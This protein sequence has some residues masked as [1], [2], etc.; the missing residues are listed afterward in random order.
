M[1]KKRTSILKT[2]VLSILATLSLLVGLLP[3]AALAETSN[4]ISQDQ[5]GKYV[6]IDDNI[7]YEQAVETANDNTTESVDST[8]NPD[9]TVQISKEIQQTGENEFQIDLTVKTKEELSSIEIEPDAAV[10]LVIDVSSSMQ[11][12]T[13]GSGYCWNEE[14]QQYGVFFENAA[15][16]DCNDFP[17]GT[18]MWR[19]NGGDQVYAGNP[20]NGEDKWDNSRLKGVV[21]AL[22]GEDG[23]L[24]SYVSGAGDGK[25][26]V[27]VVIFKKVAQELVGWTDVN[28]ANN[29][30]GMTTVTEKINNLLI[31]EYTGTGT[32]IAQGLNQVTDYREID[33][34]GEYVILLTD[35][36][37]NWKLDTT[38]ME[39]TANNHKGTDWN[40]I[41]EQA[42][43]IK[44]Y[45]D[46]LFVVD[47]LS[48]NG[49]NLKENVASQLG[50]Y[51]YA[52][53]T[54]N[55]A[56]ELRL[57]FQ[58]ISEEISK[59]AT[60]W[61]V[62]DPMG[63]Y[64]NYEEVTGGTSFGDE[65]YWF[66][67]NTLYWNLRRADSEKNVDGWAEV[68]TLSYKITLDTSA[69][70]F[71]GGKFY[72]TNDKTVLSYT[73]TTGDDVEYKEACFNVPTV[74]GKVPATTGSI[75]VT[76]EVVGSQAPDTWS[77]TFELYSATDDQEL[78]KTLTLTNAKTSGVF[79]DLAPGTYTVKEVWTANDK[80][81]TDVTN[82]GAGEGYRGSL[83]SYSVRQIQV[84][85]GGTVTVTFTNT[86]GSVVENGPSITIVK[87]VEGIDEADLATLNHNFWFT[88]TGSGDTSEIMTTVGS[89][90][91]GS[92]TTHLPAGTY[93]VE[94]DSSRAQI[95]GYILTGTTYQVGNENLS[96][97]APTIPLAEKDQVTIYIT[98]TYQ[99]S[100][101]TPDPTTGIVS[102]TKNIDGAALTSDK[103]FTFRLD[104]IGNEKSY[105][106]SVLVKAG[107]TSGYTTM[108]N[109]IEPGQYSVSEVGDVNIDGYIWN[110]VKFDQTGYSYQH[111][112]INA[113]ET[114]SITAT[115]TYEE[116]PDKGSISITKNIVG[117]SLTAN[118][119]FTFRVT[120]EAGV[121]QIISVFVPEGS[122][123][124]YNN[125]TNYFE[126]GTYT[127]EEVLDSADIDGYTL[128]DY[129]PKQTVT[130]NAGETTYVT[131]TNTYEPTTS[132]P[133]PDPEDPPVIIPDD[134]PT[135][136]I[137]KKWV[138]D[139]PS[140]R[141]DSITVDIYHD[142]E[143][144][145]SMVI[146]GLRFGDN[147]TW[148]ASYDIPERYENDDWWVVESDVP[149]NYDSETE[150]RSDTVFYIYNTYEEPVIEE[151]V[152][153]EPESSVPSSEPSEVIPSGPSEE[154]SAP[155]S[156]PTSEPSEPAEPTLP[157]TGQTWWPI[158]ILLAGGAVL[159]AFGAF[160]TM[161]GNSRHD[162]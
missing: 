161:R 65:S 133:D 109:Y 66:E 63:S 6:V 126:P 82:T 138:N 79:D 98:N 140:T 28:T 39:D 146:S 107:S 105:E 76:K 40:E 44:R 59:L 50:K 33:K 51:E 49:D 36:A 5:V 46:T 120:N 122:T 42:D 20:Q 64:I 92:S 149:A 10:T 68:Y 134:D 125:T 48:G 11:W 19:Q 160:R 89:A 154:P 2:R 112:T 129:T 159:V 47:Y 145:D 77:F 78:L 130:V 124:G 143:Y 25:R 116:V 18:E 13:N 14:C 110:G 1:K 113:G 29:P 151:P 148:R 31:D 43:T 85:A 38:G 37:P 111:I 144:Y 87:I 7:T 80:Q 74:K 75:T 67:E 155:S 62:T 94:E 8:V 71:V 103:L 99:K 131:V 72:P 73:I 88:L 16:H 106:I 61:Q 23:F 9:E 30:D 17:D 152:S 57:Y 83:Y 53:Y 24:E 136:S 102:I 141:P 60:A 119:T 4:N 97:N 58:S 108:T 104:G 101:T 147:D 135:L 21:D 153:S 35:G 158:I 84:Q 91:T 117:A 12:D 32:N 54:A 156:E 56:N 139:D 26:M 157:Q 22:T 96:E 70:G 123:T 27:R 55:N 45:A 81:P 121:S 132:D 90:G 41:K 127:I 142:G 34:T 114:T 69:E 93:T 52:Y 150:Q 86:Y 115:N 118:K 128:I 95:D 162:R 100:G 137:V 3:T 15:D